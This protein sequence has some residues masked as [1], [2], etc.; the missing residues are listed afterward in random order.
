MADVVGRLV[1]R[2]LVVRRRAGAGP[3]RSLLATAR[4]VAEREL[5]VSGDDID[6][7]YV[8]WAADSAARMEA[9]IHEFAPAAFDAVADDLRHALTLAV[10]NDGAADG[11]DD[12]DDNTAYGLARSLAHSASPAGT[13]WPLAS[14]T[15][16][17][18]W[19]R[20][21]SRRPRT[22]AWP[23]PSR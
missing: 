7:R 10:E 22:S 13:W 3:R 5:A 19:P 17:P 6:A 15:A 8:R 20:T 16:P 4:A 2:S 21:R 9:R 18:P 11:G 1:D 23:P 14:S 12:A